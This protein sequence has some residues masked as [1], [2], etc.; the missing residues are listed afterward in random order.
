MMPGAGHRS[1]WYYGWNIVGVC[2]LAQIAANAMA[3]NSFSLFLHDWS[4]EFG[5]P[6]SKFL[7]GLAGCG[8]GCSMIAPFVGVCADKYPT[9]I[10]FGGGLAGMAVFCLGISVF[11]APW[12]YYVL[13]SVVLPV[14]LCLCTSIT[15]NA[16]L[17]RWFVRRLGLALGL[18]SFGLAIAGVVMPPVIAVVM[19][20]LGWRGVW[21]IA[22]LVIALIILPLVVLVLRDRPGEENGTFYLTKDG[23]APPV[24]AHGFANT[25]TLT[26]HDVFARRNFW[27]LVIVY[28]PMLAT[29]GACG[30]NVAPLAASRGLTTHSAGILLS[31]YSVSQIAV[32]LGGGILSDKFG[33][34]L[35]LAGLAFATALGGVVVAYGHSFPMLALGIILAGSGGAFWPL[36]AA[37]VAAEFGA[38]GVGRAF[39]LLN[40]FLP[41]GVLAPF[42][43]AKMQEN[44]GSYT[45]VLLILSA[46][47]LVGGALCLLMRERRGG[48]DTVAGHELPQLVR[49]EEVL[50]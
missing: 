3:I 33:N 23:S 46:V 49:K 22:G 37:A 14:S 39:G 24:H 20:G 1:L 27:L 34:R 17:S 31:L 25:S 36:L 32:T 5:L 8:I 10:L 47:T 12:Q 26:W 40:F 13:Y 21:R 9:R 41:V 2:I 50:Y 29:Y 16:V 44:T 28:L 11:T 30:Q 45:P 6:I 35:P 4:K 42:A 7:L 18:S 19:P 38:A 15:A 48:D 43:V